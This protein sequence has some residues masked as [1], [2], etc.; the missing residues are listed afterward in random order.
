M[1]CKNLCWAYSKINV[2]AR[3]MHACMVEN[4]SL[5][6]IYIRVL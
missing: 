1:L 6:L 4:L 5:G 2:T 3:D